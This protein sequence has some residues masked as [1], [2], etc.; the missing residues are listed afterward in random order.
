MNTSPPTRIFLFAGDSL[1]EGTFGE[2]YVERVAKS[3]ELDE[4]ALHGEVINA[5]RGCDTISSLLAR[6]DEPLAQHRP[7]W[8][9]L[10]IGSNDVWLPWLARHSAVWWL[11]LLYRR[12][13]LGQKPI[14]DL[15]QFAAAYRALIDKCQQSG[16]RVLAC[17]TSPI[18][19]QLSSPVNRRMARLNGVIKH[20][21][22]EC[23]VPVA[24]VWQAFVEELTSL[25]RPSRYVPGEWLFHWMDRRRL[26]TTSPDEVARRRRLHLTFDGIHLTSQGANLWARTVLSSLVRAQG[27]LIAEPPPVV[28]RL[29]VPRFENGPIQ[30]C[31]TAGWESR[32]RDLAGLVREAYDCLALLIGAQPDVCLAVLH[33]AQWD[34]VAG[35]HAYPVPTALWDGEVGTLVMP[36]GYTRAFLREMHLPQTVA[37]WTAWPPSLTELGEPARATAVAD[38]LAVQEL[39][40]LFLRHLK[41]APSDPALNDLLT[42]YLTQVA[43]HGR[44]G[45]GMARMTAV[46]NAWG[47]ILARADVEEGHRR[48]EARALYRKHGED[49][50][51]SFTG[52]VW[53]LVRE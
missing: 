7:D 41:V 1:T 16:A 34:R 15:D 53:D 35:L 28:R 48:L 20:V 27:T 30:V 44:Q 52:S 39:A 37:S 4:L 13:R 47:E 11:W 42:A 31:Y 32:A 14:T 38:L 12:I 26:R 43:L 17:T 51:A 24:D 5:G 23:R 9:V 10:A 46:W 45:G 22:A 21:A 49:L 50:V 29:G 6:L 2:S 33:R 18:A 40:R 3:L 25:P 36:E 19:E 8:A